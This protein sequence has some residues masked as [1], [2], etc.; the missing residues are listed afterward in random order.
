LTLSTGREDILL[1]VL[2][3]LVRQLADGMDD[4]AKMSRLSDTIFYT[5][6]GAQSLLDLKKRVFHKFHFAPVDDCAMK[7]IGK[8]VKIAVDSNPSTTQTLP[9]S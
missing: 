3:G 9:A 2:K 7:G 4:F 5:G 1:G 8:L 6:G